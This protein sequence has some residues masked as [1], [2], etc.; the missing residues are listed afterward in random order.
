MN[1]HTLGIVVADFNRAITEPMLAAARDEAALLDAKIGVV[2]HVPGAYELPLITDELL[3][4][5]DITAVIV[6]GFIERGETQHGEVMAHTITGCLLTSSLKHQKPVGLGII[7][8]GAV[9][10]QAEARKEPYARAAV[11]AAIASTTEYRKAK[12][13]A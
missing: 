8:P 7:G 2:L 10:T 13:P 5:P 9:V 11:R 4:H 6:L 12:Q 3:S 1:E